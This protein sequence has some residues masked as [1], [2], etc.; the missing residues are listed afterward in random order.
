MTAIAVWTAVFIGLL[1]L[2]GFA[3]RFYPCEHWTY[4]PT[5]LALAF[6]AAGGLGGLVWA[7]ASHIDK[8]EHK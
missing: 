2:L 8:K 1:Y 4:T 5:M 6:M 3:S 7:V